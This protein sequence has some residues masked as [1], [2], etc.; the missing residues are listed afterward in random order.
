MIFEDEGS[1]S[2]APSLPSCLV[3]RVGETMPTLDSKSNRESERVREREGPAVGVA[4]VSASGSVI[5]RFLSFFRRFG[6]ASRFDA[7]PTTLSCRFIFFVWGPS[8]SSASSAS[9][10]SEM[11]R[12]FLLLVNDIDVSVRAG[13]D[14]VQ[15][16]RVWNGGG[17]GKRGTDQPRP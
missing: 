13:E 17:W 2:F 3:K 4:G 1:A 7:A 10:L 6:F 8:V 15:R 12:L 11:T 9:S 5:L 14:I 16:L